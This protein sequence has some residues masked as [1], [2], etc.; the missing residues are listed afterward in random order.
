[1]ERKELAE[2]LNRMDDEFFGKISQFLEKESFFETWYEALKD[3]D[4]DL[5]KFVYSKYNDTQF[6][7]TAKYFTVFADQ[8][9]DMLK[10]EL[11]LATNELWVW[12]LD[13]WQDMNEVL[14]EYISKVAWKDKIEVLNRVKREFLIA[15]HDEKIS[16]KEWINER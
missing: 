7:P 15:T 9:K 10:E 4:Y 3:Y 12:S 1:M 11:R 2:L 6:P 14:S 8:N 16:I 5:I 13:G